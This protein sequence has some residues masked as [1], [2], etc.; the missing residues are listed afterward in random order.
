MPEYRTFDDWF[1]EQEKFG[2]RSERFDGDVEWLKAA[3]EAGQSA[4]AKHERELLGKL[5]ISEQ[6]ISKSEIEIVRQ[7]KV[8]ARM[9]EKM[10]AMAMDWPGR[11]LAAS[12][13][14]LWGYGVL[15]Q[16]NMDDYDA[17]YQ[18]KLDR[19]RELIEEVKI[20]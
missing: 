12:L 7:A 11:K 3:F 2:L 20:G 16:S 4:S 19:A 17:N 8:I 9:Q 10:S 13:E 6:V 14:E 15:V 1:N 18:K 5:S